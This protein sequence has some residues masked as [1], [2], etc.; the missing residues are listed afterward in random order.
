MG[1]NV[2]QRRRV[3]DNDRARRLVNHRERPRRDRSGDGD[4]RLRYRAIRKAARSLSK[5]PEDGPETSADGTPD[6]DDAPIQTW[7]DDMLARLLALTAERFEHLAKR[8]LREAGFIQVEVTGRSGDGGIDGT[9][10]YR[11]SLVSFPVFFQCKRYKGGVGASQVRDFRGAMAGRGAQGILI[12]TG[13]FTTDAKAEASRAGASLIDLI[14]GDRL[15]TLLKDYK[16]GVSVTPRVVEDVAI[17][18]Q[19]FDEI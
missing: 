1:P 2:P 15:C 10:V 11:P 4:S 5:Q 17:L 14:D 8:L 6:D 18:P 9:G 19:F 7:R 13:T 12:T 3:P 16:L